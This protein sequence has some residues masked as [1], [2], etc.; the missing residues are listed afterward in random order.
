MNDTSEKTLVAEQRRQAILRLVEEQGSIRISNLGR[1]FNVTDMTIRRDIDSLSRRGF[2]RRV[3]GGAVSEI[4]GK[5]DLA[6]TFL[7]RNEEFRS[8]KELIGIRAQEF[9][10]DNSTV[11]V[12]GGSTNEYFARRLDPKKRLQVITHGLNIAWIVSGNENHELFMPGGLLNRLTMT[13]S[14]NEVVRM[15]EELNADVL[16]LS[17]SGI[18]LEKGLTDPAWLDTSIKKAMIRASRRVILLIDSHKFDLVSPR[19]FA[20]AEEVDFVVTDRALK[21]EIRDKYERG[22]LNLLEA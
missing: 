12:D 2:V 14:G 1:Q 20:S 17:A 6:T 13:F 19:T 9:V 15:Y 5:I 18:S 21:P 8:E 16:F 22:G 4:E 3:H 11:I 7:K 10:E